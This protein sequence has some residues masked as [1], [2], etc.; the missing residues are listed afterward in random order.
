MARSQSAGTKTTRSKKSSTTGQKKTSSKQSQT[1]PKKQSNTTKE[2]NSTSTTRSAKKA[3]TKDTTS[4]KKISTVSK[5]Q[6]NL[7]SN[8]KKLTSPKQPQKTG[9][10]SGKIQVIA[11]GKVE[12]FP[13]STFP[14]RLEDKT[15]NKVCYFQC[16][17]HAV[18]YINRYNPDYKL[19]CYSV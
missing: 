7:Q 15:D 4:Q 16:E 1:T 8:L 3:T 13:H 10:N 5:T 9:K 6:R 14:Y 18:K 11:S 12:L 19:Y 2:K 17:D